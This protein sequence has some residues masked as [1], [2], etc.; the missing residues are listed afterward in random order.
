M[1]CKF[2]FSF[3]SIS[4]KKVRYEARQKETKRQNPTKNNLT[5]SNNPLNLTKMH[6]DK[7]FI[8]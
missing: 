2:Q 6:L 4:R 5:V 3:L 1:F 8:E 7:K